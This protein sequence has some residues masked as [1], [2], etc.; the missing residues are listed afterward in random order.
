MPPD[1]GRSHTRDGCAPRSA[2]YHLSTGAGFRQAQ[3]CESAD[4]GIRAAEARGYRVVDGLT[5]LVNQGVIG[6]KYWTGVD[7]EASVMRK[8]LENL[9]RADH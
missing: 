2:R 1:D 4:R 8:E 3:T 5:M 6:I 7:V 9:L